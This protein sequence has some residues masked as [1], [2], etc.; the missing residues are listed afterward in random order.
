MSTSSLFKRKISSQQNFK[1][2]QSMCQP[3]INWY[4]SIVATW[5]IFQSQRNR[6]FN[7]EKFQVYGETSSLCVFTSGNRYDYDFVIAEFIPLLQEKVRSVT[8]I[9][10]L[11]TSY[12]CCSAPHSRCIC[13]AACSR[14]YILRATVLQQRKFLPT[15]HTTGE[16][17]EMKQ[18]LLSIQVSFLY[19]DVFKCQ[20]SSTR[21]NY[22]MWPYSISCYTHD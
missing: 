11:A 7:G 17:L 1:S 13:R 4:Y 8:C 5:K 18:K 15:C 2:L 20:Y 12:G 3:N 21:V 10:L 9:V 22:D 6:I 14:N 19:Q 16:K